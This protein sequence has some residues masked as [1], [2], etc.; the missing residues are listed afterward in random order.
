VRMRRASM[1]T[2]AAVVLAAL[3]CVL[4]GSAAAA[5]PRSG[6]V[7][8]AQLALAIER[9]ADQSSFA[10]LERFGQEAG[11]RADP[12]ALGRVQHVTWTFLNQAEFDRF[13]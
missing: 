12:E 13:E 6:T 2:K 7:G 5:A 8:P 9:R 1:V 10:D 3:F 4:T 11:R